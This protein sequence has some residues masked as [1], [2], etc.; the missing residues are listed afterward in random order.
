M[1]ALVFAA[2]GIVLVAGAARADGPSIAT[3]LP[4][5]TRGNKLYIFILKSNNIS[6]HMNPQDFCRQLGYG[7][8][9]PNF[10]AKGPD[11]VGK[12]LGTLIP[13]ELTWVVCEVPSN[14]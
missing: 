4:P 2:I 11:E 9:V 14:K 6:L 5:N 12:D 1:R 13:G 3:E 10:S 8:A 7:D